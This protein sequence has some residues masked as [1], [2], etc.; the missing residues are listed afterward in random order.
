V[1]DDLFCDLN[2]TNHQQKQPTVCGENAFS[3]KEVFLARRQAPAS[4]PDRNK[5]RRQQTSGTFASANADGE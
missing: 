1:K 5:Q 3:N 4:L 2:R